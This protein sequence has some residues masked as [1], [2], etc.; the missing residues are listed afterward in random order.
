MP[1]QVVQDTEKSRSQGNQENQKGESNYWSFIQCY[2]AKIMGR[3]VVTQTK[4]P[5]QVQT[6]QQD[7][8]I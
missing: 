6:Q 1:A 5:N 2:L 4:T 3:M 7:F 8:L